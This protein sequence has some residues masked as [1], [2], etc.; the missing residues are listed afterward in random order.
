MGERGDTLSQVPEPE[1]E[2]RLIRTQQNNTKAR[3][4]F[5]PCFLLPGDGGNGLPR[6]AN[7]PRNDSAKRC[8]DLIHRIP[9][10]HAERSPY[11]PCGA[12][13]TLRAYAFPRVFR[14]LRKKSPRFFCHRQREDSF[15]PCSGEALRHPE[16]K[17]SGCFWWIMLLIAACFSIIMISKTER[18]ACSG[19]N[20]IWD[21]EPSP[22][23]N[24]QRPAEE[25]I[26]RPS[27]RE[28]IW[29]TPWNHENPI[30]KPESGRKTYLEQW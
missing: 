23:P 14:P 6:A 10:G 24:M 22:V 3:C 9:A 19:A 25:Q 13:N 21:K 29:S 27:W 2:E 8:G 11:P 26:R 12:R 30:S 15:P 1:R 5:A 16:G 18:I 28:E 4:R 7:G 20:R 17:P